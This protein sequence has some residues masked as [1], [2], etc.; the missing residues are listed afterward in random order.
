MSKT[1]KTQGE[2]FQGIASDSELDK[3]DGFYF[4]PDEEDYEENYKL[5]FFNFEGEKSGG[6]PIESSEM[7]LKYHMCFFKHDENNAPV[8]DD[9]FEAILVNPLDYIKIGRAHV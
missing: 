1:K 9:A 6:T 5:V 7:G 3:F 8:F 2:G 4:I